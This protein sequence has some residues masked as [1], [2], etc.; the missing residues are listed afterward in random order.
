VQKVNSRAASLNTSFQLND[1]VVLYHIAAYQ[2][3]APKAA[4]AKSVRYYEEVVRLMNEMVGLL[5]ENN[6]MLKQHN[7]TVDQLNDAVRK[8]NINTGNLR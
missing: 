5:K 2:L 6:A 8:I 1:E 4:D 7:L 3:M